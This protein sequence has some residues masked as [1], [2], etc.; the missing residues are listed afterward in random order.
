[1]HDTGV[2][3]IRDTFRYK[4]HA[5]PIPEATTTDCILKATHHFTM[6]I[7]GIQEAAPDE[8]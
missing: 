2:E 6:A 5:T 8:L 1:M 7:E 4:H 3:H